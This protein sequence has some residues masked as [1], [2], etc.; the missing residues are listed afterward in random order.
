MSKFSKLTLV[1]SCLLVLCC[2]T[3]T[4]KAEDPAAEKIKV[5]IVDGQNNHAEWPKITAM[6]KQYLEESEKFT[7]DAVS[8]THLTLPTIY[9]V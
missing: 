5:L 8:Y 7:V 1:A 9:S 3:V 6:L 4:V 2:L